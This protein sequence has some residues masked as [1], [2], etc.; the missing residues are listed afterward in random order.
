MIPEHWF[1][2]CMKKG[3]FLWGIPQATGGVTIEQLCTHTHG[4][5]DS[6]HVVLIPSRLCTS[7]FQKQ[8]G[9][10]VELLL[11]VESD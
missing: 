4:V 6:L 7:L 2:Q 8:L 11:T 10:V 5:P 3:C 9:K 1:D